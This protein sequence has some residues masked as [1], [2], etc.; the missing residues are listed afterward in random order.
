[1]YENG[2]FTR[3]MREDKRYSYYYDPK[4]NSSEDLQNSLFIWM[5]TWSAPPR[6]NGSGFS[7]TN[8]ID[9]IAEPRPGFMFRP[10]PGNCSGSA[11]CNS[12]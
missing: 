1:M 9:Q 5:G 2:S 6:I 8:T 4:T 7:M 10:A 3:V 11:Q 12:L